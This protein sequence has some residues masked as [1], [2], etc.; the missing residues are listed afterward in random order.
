MI[1]GLSHESPTAEDRR[2]DRQTD[3]RTVAHLLQAVGVELGLV[4]DL[5]GHLWTEEAVNYR[6]TTLNFSTAL[7]LASCYF[8]PSMLLLY[9]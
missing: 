8:S 5:D 6:L 7:A 9:N 4:Y 1:P 2:T 3:R